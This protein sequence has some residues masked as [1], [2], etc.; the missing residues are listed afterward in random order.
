M[1]F[2]TTNLISHLIDL[3]F[4]QSSFCSIPV[5]QYDKDS[6][7]IEATLYD[8]GSSYN[9][10][11][12]TTA[13]FGGTKPSSHIVLETA[14]IENN[15]IYYKISEQCTVKEGDY[16]V[17]FTLHLPNGAVKYTQEFKIQVRKAVISSDAIA[18]V[19]EVNVLNGLIVDASQSISGANIATENANNAADS[20]NDIADQLEVET[21]IIWKPYV[22]TYVNIATTYPTPELGWTTQAQDTGIRWRYNGTEWI[23]IGVVSDDKVGDLSTVTTT[24]K[25]NVVSAINELNSQLAAITTLTDT[26][27]K[28]YKHKLQ[29]SA[30]GIM[31]ISYE[32][33]V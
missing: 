5:E 32:E 31:Q 30:Q 14:T 12:G 15:K 27:N 21:L 3:D 8:N 4:K 2:N 10:P 20:A 26:D 9:I 24:N 22:S 33:V 16:P 6:A 25:T 19:D 23:N 13:S 1:V 17:K 11:I 28:K 7:C 29:K 18:D